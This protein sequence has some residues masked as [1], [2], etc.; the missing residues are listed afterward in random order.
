MTSFFG[1]LSSS[2]LRR[3]DRVYHGL[4]RSAILLSQSNP[5]DVD[6]TALPLDRL[7][8]SALYGKIR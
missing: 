5:G 8:H 2:L 6:A 1:R 7:R 3:P 4:A